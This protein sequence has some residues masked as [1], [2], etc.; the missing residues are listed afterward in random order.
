MEQQSIHPG[1]IGGKRRFPLECTS[2]PHKGGG[3]LARKMANLNRRQMAR[4]ATIKASRVEPG[5]FKMPGSMNQH[6]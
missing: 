4:D 5:A 6:K 2:K 3:K 1:V